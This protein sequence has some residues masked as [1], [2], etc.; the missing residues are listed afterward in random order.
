MNG[1]IQGL[2]NAAGQHLKHFLAVTGWGRRPFPSGAV[3]VVPPALFPQPA[4]IP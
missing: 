3:G 1:N 4:L 2:L